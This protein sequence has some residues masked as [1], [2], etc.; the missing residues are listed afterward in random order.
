MA[1]LD[2]ITM[3]N[4]F[5]F[6]VGILLFTLMRDG[7]HIFHSSAHKS[8]LNQS[9]LFATQLAKWFEKSKVNVRSH[10]SHS[11]QLVVGTETRHSCA[12]GKK[13]KKKKKKQTHTHIIFDIV[14]I[15][16]NKYQT[17]CVRRAYNQRII[18][19]SDIR[20]P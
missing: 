3:H 7:T 2:E 6:V 5:L 4:F 10:L 16:H 9:D 20:T 8:N 1:T 13:M 11:L 15:F 19:Y 14:S 12:N 17:D 18:Y